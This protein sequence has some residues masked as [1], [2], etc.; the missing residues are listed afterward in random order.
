MPPL[1][2]DGS[3]FD[4][5]PHDGM[6]TFFETSFHFAPPSFVYQ[7]LPSLVPAQINPRSISD[8]AIAKITSGAN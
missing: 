5:T 7:T 4:T 6:P 1:K 3:I 8:A 2:W